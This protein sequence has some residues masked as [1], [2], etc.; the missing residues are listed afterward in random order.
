M[1]LRYIT[2]S[3]IN[4]NVPYEEIIKLSTESNLFEIG[5]IANKTTMKSDT[6]Q[7]V[8]L[9]NLL[10]DRFSENINIAMHL[11]DTLCSDFC[12]GKVSSELQKYLD[13]RTSNNKPFIPR[14]QL[15]I[16]SNMYFKDVTN[17]KSIM[18]DNQD[19]EFIFSFNKNPIILSFINKL[20]ATGAKFSLL[21]NS[22]YGSG[23][24]PKSWDVPYIGGYHHGYSG[25]LC[26]D[27][28]YDNLTKISHVVPSSY[29]TWIDAEHNLK[30]PNSNQLDIEK[31]KAY[32]K[33]ALKWQ[34]EHIK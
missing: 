34:K 32:V 20:Y 30:K 21:Y 7:N 9:K 18:Q 31:A 10:S 12:I 3:G 33:N 11:D 25:G 1:K 16:T 17:I 29:N 2:C 5:I 15:N 14:W 6:A 4:E 28:V 24:L 19:K 23:L 8:W 27:N 22:S 13:L 26:A